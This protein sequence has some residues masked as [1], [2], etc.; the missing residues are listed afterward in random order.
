MHIGN[1]IYINDQYIII[2][3]DIA[4]FH[5]KKPPQNDKNIYYKNGEKTEIEITT[6]VK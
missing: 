2:V 6:N 4:Y 1:Y 5:I 3:M